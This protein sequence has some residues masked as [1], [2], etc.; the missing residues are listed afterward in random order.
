MNF[1]YPFSSTAQITGVTSDLLEE[2]P[3][4]FSDPCTVGT[5]GGGTRRGMRIVD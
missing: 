5:E 2:K 3:R 1:S 4:P